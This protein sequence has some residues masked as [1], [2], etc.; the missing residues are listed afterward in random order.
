MVNITPETAR[1]SAEILADYAIT[2][3]DAE[4]ARQALAVLDALVTAKEPQGAARLVRGQLYEVIAM[5][6]ENYA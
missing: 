4:V 5:A 2:N 1:H 3:G 6:A